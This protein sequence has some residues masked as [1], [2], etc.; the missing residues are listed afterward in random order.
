MTLM[1][2]RKINLLIEN[3][4]NNFPTS[5]RLNHLTSMIDEFFN[6]ED[7]IAQEDNKNDDD[8]EDN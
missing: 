6:D 4:I 7:Q 1:K 8:D 5:V 3:G 2:I